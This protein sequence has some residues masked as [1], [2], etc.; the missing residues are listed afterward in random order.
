LDQRQ[1]RRN[2]SLYLGDGTSPGGDNPALAV[3]VPSP[4]GGTGPSTPTGIVA[5]TAKI[6]KLKA[7]NS[8][9]AAFIF[10]T[11]DGTISAWNGPVGFPGAPSWKLTTQ[12]PPVR[13]ARRERFTRAWPRARPPREYFFKRPTLPVERWAFSMEPSAGYRTWRGFKDSLIPAGYAPFGKYSRQPGRRL[14][15]T[16]CQ[17]T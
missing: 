15:Q 16:G 7:P 13:M 17:E 12:P 4:N 6:L 10:A 9:A 8:T 11:E 5:N 14:R 2:I 1:R 3:T